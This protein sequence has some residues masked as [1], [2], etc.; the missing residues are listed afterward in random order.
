M[1]P[2]VHEN[3]MLFHLATFDGRMVVGSPRTL[4]SHKNPNDNHWCDWT[5]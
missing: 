3:F 5:P 2:P 1:G 4:D